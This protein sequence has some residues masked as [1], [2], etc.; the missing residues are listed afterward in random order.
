MITP[1]D[2]SFDNI[3]LAGSGMCCCKFKTTLISSH[4]APGPFGGRTKADFGSLPSSDNV[5][6]LCYI[7]TSNDLFVFGTAP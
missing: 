6:R 3:L 2:Q 7:V 1:K 5:M 4:T